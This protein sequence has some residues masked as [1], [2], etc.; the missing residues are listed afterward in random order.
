MSEQ[1]NQGEKLIYEAW[2]NSEA[3]QVPMT[4][5]GQKIAE[6]RYYA[7]IKGW[8]Y[9]MFYKKHNHVDMKSFLENYF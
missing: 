8:E 7:F 6:Q 5:L 3:Y 2:R 4:E 9:A 1:L